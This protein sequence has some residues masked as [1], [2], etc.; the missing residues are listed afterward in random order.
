MQADHQWVNH[1]LKIAQGQISGLLKMV[2]EDAYCM[3]ISNQILACI[4]VLKKT[5]AAVLSAHMEHCVLEAS[6]KEEAK[7]KLKEIESL[8]VKLTN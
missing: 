3:D 5:N 8:L 2:E 4:A 7:E 6:G 1:Q